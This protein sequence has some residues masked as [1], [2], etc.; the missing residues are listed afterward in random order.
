M[1]IHH[2]YLNMER[3]V[4]IMGIDI[5]EYL[6]SMSDCNIMLNYPAKYNFEIDPLCNCHLPIIIIKYLI[7]Y[8]KYHNQHL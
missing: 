8:Y 7:K 6:T 2:I 1:T 3:F 5:E 4:V